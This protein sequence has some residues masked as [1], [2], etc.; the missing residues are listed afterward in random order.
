MLAPL[1]DIELGNAFCAYLRVPVVSAQA[2]LHSQCPTPTVR[3]MM[4][5]LPNILLQKL[6]MSGDQLTANQQLSAVVVHGKMT[7]FS[8]VYHACMVGFYQKREGSGQCSRISAMAGWQG[9]VPTHQ[10]QASA[11]CSGQAQHRH[12]G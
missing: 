6:R 11:H 1:L 10:Y 4:I 3:N 7:S 9:G 5:V 12:H 8:T 2:L